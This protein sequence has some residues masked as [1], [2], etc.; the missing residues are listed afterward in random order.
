MKL[1]LNV[2]FWFDEIDNYEFSQEEIKYYLK[3]LLEYGAEDTNSEIELI[4]MKC[5]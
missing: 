1:T 4:N 5:E 2:D 3:Q